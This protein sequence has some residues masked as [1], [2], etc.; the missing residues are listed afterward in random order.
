MKRLF[1]AAGIIVT[2]AT[3]CL[4]TVTSASSATG[5]LQV[6]GKTFQNPSGCYESV[7]QQLNV[8]N[9]TNEAV[10]LFAAAGCKGPATGVVEP[11]TGLS[12]S[13]PGPSV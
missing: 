8:H 1:E 2:A 4:V 3:P 13:G 10:L 6:G 9:H 5:E 12:S 7:G 11:N